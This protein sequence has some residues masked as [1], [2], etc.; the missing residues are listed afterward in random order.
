MG[1]DMKQENVAFLGIVHKINEI[2]DL[3]FLG[4]SIVV[5]VGVMLQV[6]SGYYVEV[7]GP[8]RARVEDIVGNF[9]T[10]EFES[11]PESTRT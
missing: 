4:C 7:V 6:G 8:G 11:H 5:G 10:D 2:V 9:L 3:D 1:A